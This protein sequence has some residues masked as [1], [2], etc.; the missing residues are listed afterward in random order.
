MNDQ[1]PIS[2]QSNTAASTIRPQGRQL[3][4]QRYAGSEMMEKYKSEHDAKRLRLQYGCNE[5][6]LY[7]EKRRNVTAAMECPVQRYIN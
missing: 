4:C 3:N 2:K 5:S 6:E 7:V 1:L